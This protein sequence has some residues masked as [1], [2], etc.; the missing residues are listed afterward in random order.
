MSELVI[1]LGLVLVAGILQGSFI[2]PMTF[3][4]RWQWEHS[5]ALFS[6][7]GMIVLNWLLAAWAMPDLLDVYRATQGSDIAALVLFGLLWGAGAILFGLGMDRLGMSVGYPII[8]GLI[9]S[10]GAIIPLLLQNP[11]ELISRGGLLLLIGTA[12]TIVGIVLCSRAAAAKYAQ[13]SEHSPAA[14]LRV[15]L[16]IAILA[17]TFSCFPNVGMNYA[18]HLK[19]A[20]IKFGASENM[21]GNAAWSL[22]FTAGFVLNFGYCA[23]LTLRRGNFRQLAGDFGRNVSWII[24]MA[25]L[26][27]GS[28][29]LY[30]MGAAR[31][32]KWG[33]VVGWP[34]FISLAIVVGNL[35]GLWRG[36]WRTAKASARRQLNLGLAVLLA[37]VAIFGIASALK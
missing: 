6:L 18:V 26:W 27:I 10:L 22:M 30:G 17:G 3:A 20:A 7:F 32:G 33:G 19:A 28:F 35:W 14:N 25:A 4:R 8:M 2:L 11:A 9:L 15:G 12:I 5:W 34:L 24:L 1:G 36:E 21:A 23:W 13:P 31:M 37:A 16:V 29:Y